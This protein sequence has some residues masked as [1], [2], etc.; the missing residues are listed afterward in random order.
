MFTPAP[1]PGGPR[2]R[3]PPIVKKR[4]DGLERR[5]PAGIA[6]ER[7][8]SADDTAPCQCERLTP[9]STGCRDRLPLPY[10]GPRL[11]HAKRGVQE[12]LIMGVSPGGARHQPAGGGRTAQCCC[13]GGADPAKDHRPDSQSAGSRHPYTGQSALRG[14]AGRGADRRSAFQAVPAL[15]PRWRWEFRGLWPRCRPEVGVPSR[16]RA[17]ALLAMR[18]AGLKAVYLAGGA[19]QVD[20]QSLEESPL[21]VCSSRKGFTRSSGSGKM[22]VEFFSLAMSVSV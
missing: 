17:F 6:R 2:N 20:R 14:P 21:P 12:D 19:G 16:P 3:V 11:F 7:E 22:M 15:L 4:G 10:P 18:G 13:P 5:P 1:R 8:T 9:P